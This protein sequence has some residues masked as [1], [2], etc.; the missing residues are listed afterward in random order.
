MPVPTDPLKEQQIRCNRCGNYA[1][2]S[3]IRC[4]HCGEALLTLITPVTVPVLRRPLTMPGDNT[5]YRLFPVEAR[6]I[7]Q[8][9]PSGI[10]LPVDVRSPLVLGREDGGSTDEILDLTEFNAVKHGVSRRHVLLQR[11]GSRLLVSDLGSTNGTHLNGSLILPN[12]E[13]I[14]AHGDKLILGTLHLLIS[15]ST[16]ESEL[17]DSTR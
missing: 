11:D 13:H 8:L 14:I 15:F 6:A 3:A 9:L 17:G 10:C 5:A 2:P 1:P 12:Q 16:F 4:P 7:L